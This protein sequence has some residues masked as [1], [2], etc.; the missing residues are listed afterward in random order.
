MS[1]IAAGEKLTDAAATA[2]EAAELVCSGAVPT[3]RRPL[4]GNQDEPITASSDT[5]LSVPT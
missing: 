2:T 5:L 3:L 4:Q 1:V